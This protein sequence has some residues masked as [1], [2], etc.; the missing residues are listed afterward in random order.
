MENLWMQIADEE[1]IQTMRLLGSDERYT[2]GDASDFECLEEW[3]LARP[4]L[5]GN[6]VGQRTAKRLCELLLCDDVSNIGAAE[7]WSAYNALR[8][9]AD[10]KICD[11]KSNHTFSG[12]KKIYCDEKDNSIQNALDVSALVDKSEGSFD[13]VREYISK[14]DIFCVKADLRSDV[15]RRPDRYAA[16]VVLKNMISGEKYNIDDINVLYSQIIC[17]IAYKFKSGFLQL[18]LNAQNGLGAAV[19]LIKYLV[20]RRLRVRV[21]LCVDADTDVTELKNACL[22]S[23]NDCFVTPV[24]LSCKS[25]GIEDFKNRLAKIY[26]IGLLSL[27]P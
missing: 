8:L 12:Y 16:E 21:Y 11:E 15:F 19:G 24:L 6:E 14:N 2:D 20:S 25:D 3:L 1:L 5:E 18:Y 4:L 22:C 27:A 26:P 17:E 13:A 7:A 10:V 9:G 23:G